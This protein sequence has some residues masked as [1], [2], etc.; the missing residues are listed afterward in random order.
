M[1][2]SF[3]MTTLLAYID[4]GSASMVFQAVLGGALAVIYLASSRV[5]SWWS[6]LRALVTRLGPRSR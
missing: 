2:D 6:H 4:G 1:H 3:P 5:G